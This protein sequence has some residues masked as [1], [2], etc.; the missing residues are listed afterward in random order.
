MK[1]KPPKVRLIDDKDFMIQKVKPHEPKPDFMFRSAV[2][3]AWIQS[4]ICEFCGTPSPSEACHLWLETVTKD[5][6]AKGEKPHDYWFWPGC[7]LHH[8]IQHF[9]GERTFWCSAHGIPDPNRYILEKYALKSP[10]P[11]TRDI[12]K[13]EHLRRYGSNA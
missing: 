9:I 7:H 11:A 8:R 3:K 2:H 1:Q 5:G 10:C 13:I 6:S 4:Q 12:A